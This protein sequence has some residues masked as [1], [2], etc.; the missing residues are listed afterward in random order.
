M[1]LYLV[2]VL[3]F[4]LWTGCMLHITGQLVPHTTT[5][6]LT[7]LTAK[8]HSKLTHYQELVMKRLK[9]ASKPDPKL[10]DNETSKRTDVVENLV[11]RKNRHEI[12]VEKMERRRR[13]RSRRAQGCC[14]GG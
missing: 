5:F 2:T 12:E 11:S 8:D 6:L 9:L 4:Q 13:R 7:H 14:S 1:V 10:A 3:L